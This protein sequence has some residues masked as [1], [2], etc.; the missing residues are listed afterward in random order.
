M[1]RASI[2]LLAGLLVAAPAAAQVA[3]TRTAII[4]QRENALLADLAACESGGHRDPNNSAYLGRFQFSTVTVINFVRER[5]GR[6]IG[7]AEARA[8]ARDAAQAGRL[9][10]YMIFERN[11]YTHWPACSRKLRIPAKVADIKATAI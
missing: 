7:A 11:G 8:I 1:V 10:R 6:T 5:D 3:D 9:V 4:E 2:W